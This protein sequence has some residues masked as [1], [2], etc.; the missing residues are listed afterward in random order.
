[1]AGECLIF[2]LLL[3]RKV[4]GVFLLLRLHPMSSVAGEHCSILKC[5]LG[6][7]GTSDIS[8]SSCGTAAAVL[9]C[10][11]AWQD[12]YIPL[13][14][15]NF[16]QIQPLWEDEQMSSCRNQ[17]STLLF[18]YILISSFSLSPTWAYH[19]WRWDIQGSIIHK[20]V[21]WWIAAMRSSHWCIE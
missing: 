10:Y 12:E 9:L 19:H 4:F 20:P 13:N 8:F 17:P 7:K 5:N 1:M 14:S 6:K 21:V 15:A 11:L 18:G 3:M 16:N 2:L